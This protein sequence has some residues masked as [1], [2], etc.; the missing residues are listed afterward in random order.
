MADLW[1]PPLSCLIPQM[2]GGR[3]GGMWLLFLCLFGFTTVL[4]PSDKKF[5]III[6]LLLYYYYYIPAG[7]TNWWNSSGEVLS[8]I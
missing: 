2:L 4:G 3:Q 5:I 1:G 7:A 6:L 8:Q